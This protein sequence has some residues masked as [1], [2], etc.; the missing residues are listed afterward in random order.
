[1]RTPR[2]KSLDASI[3]SAIL[4]PTLI[5]AATTFDCNHVRVDKQSFDLS[6]LGGPRSVMTSEPDGLLSMNTTYTIDICQPLVKPKNIEGKDHYCPNGSRVCGLVH[7]IEMETGESELKKVIPIAGSLKD[8]GGGQLDA[9]WTRLTTSP[10][11]SDI[12][13]EGL[14]VELNGGIYQKDKKTKQPQKAIV[15]F[16]CDPEKTGLEGL[17]DDGNTYEDSDKKRR[18]TSDDEGDGEDDGDDIESAASLKFIKYDDGGD[19][20]VL[21]LEWRTKYAC[22]GKKDED[23]K[24]RSDSWGFFTWFIIVAFLAIAA[25]LIFGSWLNYNRYGARGWDLLPHGDTI[26]DVPYI[27]KDWTRKVVTTVQGGGSRGGYSAV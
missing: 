3:L 1:M 10:S 26:R 5:V 19:T 7:E 27:M 9:S 6:S 11:N 16:L 4:F 18:A 2:I 22:E 14:R 12:E 13:K 23:D 25:Y 8:H 21:R 15:E 24:A 20:G 17:F